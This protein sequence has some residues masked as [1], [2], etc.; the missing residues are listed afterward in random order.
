MEKNIIDIFQQE[1]FKILSP[2]ELEILNDWKKQGYTDEQIRDALKESILS[3]VKN[4]RYIEK[5]LKSSE[6]LSKSTDTA[7]EE[8]D[9][10]WLG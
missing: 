7:V 6:P 1:F 4:F 10:S 2:I 3:G 9:L 5:V 8:K